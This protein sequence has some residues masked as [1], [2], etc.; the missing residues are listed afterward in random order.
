[1][2][3]VTAGKLLDRCCEFEIRQEGYYAGIRDRSKDNSVRLLTYYLAL[4][5]RHR[6]QA[7]AAHGKLQVASLRK[8]KIKQAAAFEPG[9]WF[10]LFDTPPEQ[11]GGVELL[12]AAGGYYQALLDLYRFMREQVLS[13][14]NRDVL[15]SLIGAEERD[16]AMV[17]QMTAMHY[18]SRSG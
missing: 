14:E 3:T 12:Q 8:M 2:P 18:F 15:E 5:R 11:V 17:K 16:V 7:L 13:D 10:R 4:H 1:M 6:E 9:E